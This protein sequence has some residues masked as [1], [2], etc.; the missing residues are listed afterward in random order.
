L[1]FAHY[2]SLQD[3]VVLITGGGSGIGG[4][5]T[6][7]FA[8]QGAR[9][10]FIDID[11]AASAALVERLSGARHPPLFIRADLNDI[12]ALRSAVARVLAEVGPVSVLVNNAANDERH[13]V[14]DVTPEY[15]D[16]AMNVNLRHQFFAA[17]AV[18]PHMRAL[19]HG[20]II[21]LSS[22]AFMFGGSDFTV[23]ATAKAGVVGLTNALARAFGG[24]RIRVNAIA[25]GAVMTEKQ[26]RLWYTDDT[27]DAMARR[28]MIP[29]RLLPEEVARAALFLAADDSRMITKQ[30]LLVDAGIR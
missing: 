1:T 20:S 30:C 24:D 9:V 6:E 12:G 29:E 16:G 27:A 28:Q 19:G 4:A 23:Y 11:E 21:N 25:P 15:W 3:R 8:A 22:T 2:P 26:L 7:A 18:H 5:M 17:Q 14:A 13:A 10:A